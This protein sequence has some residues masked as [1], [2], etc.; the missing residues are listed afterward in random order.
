MQLI[1]S[2]VTFLAKKQWCIPPEESA[3]FAAPMEDVLD[4][5]HRARDAKNPV[6]C[7]DETS[8]EHIK[9]IRRPLPMVEGSPLRYDCEYQRNG[10][11]NLFMIFAPLEGL[12]HVEVTDTRASVDFAHNQEA[13]IEHLEKIRWNG[14]PKCPHCESERVGHIP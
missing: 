7:V 11:S 8:K 3:E 1:R 5:Y 6:V 14:D 4:V 10:V 13:C 2:V 9:E 12:R